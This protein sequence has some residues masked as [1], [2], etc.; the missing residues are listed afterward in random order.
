MDKGKSGRF[1]PS[2]AFSLL[3]FSIIVFCFSVLYLDSTESACE[4]TDFFAEEESP[5]SENPDGRFNAFYI[6]F[7]IFMRIQ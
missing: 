2:W 6:F 4:A 3:N 1:C 5:I 7:F